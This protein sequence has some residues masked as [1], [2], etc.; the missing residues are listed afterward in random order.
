[1]PVS[2]SLEALVS[3]PAAQSLWPEEFVALVATIAQAPDEYTSWAVLSDWLKEHGEY[4]M[5]TACR[6]FITRQEI[7]VQH[8]NYG[9]SYWEFKGLPPSVE[10]CLEEECRRPTLAGAIA[11]LAA[12]L[13]Q[14]KSEGA[15][16]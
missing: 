16:I 7:H 2:V 11:L 15:I 12:K 14:H 13:R 1:M 5:E 8:I 10:R 4:D 6:Y 9:T 3:I